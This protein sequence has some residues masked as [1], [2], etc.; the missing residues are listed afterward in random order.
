MPSTNLFSLESEA[1]LS[2]ER[3]SFGESGLSPLQVLEE[4]ELWQEEI[5][6]DFCTR[7]PDLC[8]GAG[9][10]ATAKKRREVGEVMTDIQ[11]W[12]QHQEGEIDEGVKQIADLLS[13]LHEK[14]QKRNPELHHKK[15]KVDRFLLECP[16]FWERIRRRKVRKG[17][18]HSRI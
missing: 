11:D 9:G 7:L 3:T 16:K 1:G 18:H 2:T 10:S 14:L 6:L 17:R 8:R 15:K 5:I 4:E 12:I 13:T